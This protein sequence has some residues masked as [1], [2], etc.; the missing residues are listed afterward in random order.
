MFR[1]GAPASQAV[2]PDAK[3]GRLL[4]AGAR[5]VRS[6][7]LRSAQAD[8]RAGKTLRTGARPGDAAKRTAPAERSGRRGGRRGAC[9]LRLGAP[10]PRLDGTGEG[11]EPSAQ[12]QTAALGP[13]PRRAGLA[14]RC[15]PRALAGTG[16]VRALRG[17]L[18]AGL[19][20]QTFR[21]KTAPAPPA[22]APRSP[23]GPPTVRPLPSVAKTH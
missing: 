17:R 12:S 7:V 15:S 13:Q 9:S 23:P 5:G 22:G 11:G 3:T 10:P 19:G 6:R 1:P 18:R 16:A 14:T 20:A 2:G 4:S 21:A 8:P